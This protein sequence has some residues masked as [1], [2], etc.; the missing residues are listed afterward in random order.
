M[1]NPAP[2]SSGWPT[3]RRKA[4][5]RRRLPRRQ[6]TPQVITRPDFDE[7]ARNLVDSGHAP[8][9]ILDSASAVRRRTTNP[10]K[11]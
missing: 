3:H 11:E 4:R 6:P 1:T 8:L 2:W 7:V 10:P 5:D 9:S